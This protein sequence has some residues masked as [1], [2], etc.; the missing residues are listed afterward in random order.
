MRAERARGRRGSR[1]RGAGDQVFRAPLAVPCAICAVLA[2]RRGEPPL[3]AVLLP[4]LVAL[5][6]LLVTVRLARPRGVLERRAVARGAVRSER[7]ALLLRQGP[8]GGVRLDRIRAWSG[9]TR[10]SARAARGGVRAVRHRIAGT[11]ADSVCPLRLAAAAAAPARTRAYPGGIIAALG[12]VRGEGSDRLKSAGECLGPPNA[13]P[14]RRSGSRAR[15]GRTRAGGFR[16]PRPAC[17]IRRGVL[18]RTSALL[19]GC[20]RH[21]RALRRILRATRFFLGRDP[22]GSQGDRPSPGLR[23]FGRHADPLRRIAGLFE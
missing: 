9:R 21:S 11:P 16:Q 8:S 18:A 5:A 20:A 10:E 12:R 3:R 17:S 13:G 6:F 7:A 14:R 15:G 19:A 22:A 1:R 23:E 2:L 4:A